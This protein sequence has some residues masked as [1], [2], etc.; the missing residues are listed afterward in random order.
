MSEIEKIVKYPVKTPSQGRPRDF[1]IL[2]YLCNGINVKDLAK[3][4]NKNIHGG[5]I[6]FIR[7]KIERSTKQD[8]KPIVVVIIPEIEAIIKK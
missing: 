4:K 5:V 6:T 2:T 3:L 8:L 7:S 1:W